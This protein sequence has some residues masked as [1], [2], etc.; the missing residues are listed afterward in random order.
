MLLVTHDLD[1][2]FELGDRMLVVREGRL[3]QTGSPRDVASR[4]AN[5]EVARLLG[6]YNLLPAEIRALDPGRN[7]SRLAVQGIDIA[8]TYIPGHLIGDRI[9]LCIRP[10]SLRAFPRDGSLRPNQIPF[11][12]VRAVDKPAGV[13]LEFNSGLAVD[14][15]RGTFDPAVKEWVVEFP[16]ASIQV[17]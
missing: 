7:T 3:V 16:P 12:I 6:L 11:S 4:P 9:T 2:C 8:G 10:D 13:R 1:E 17:L 14:M 15:P 5:L